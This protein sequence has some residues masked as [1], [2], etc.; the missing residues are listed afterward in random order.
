MKTAAETRFRLNAV[1]L[2]FTA[3][4][5]R[6]KRCVESL[7]RGFV[8]SGGCKPLVLEPPDEREISEAQDMFWQ[9]YQRGV[10][11]GREEERRAV[12]AKPSKAKK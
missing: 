11:D 3:M 6:S 5:Y 8:N 7:M 12:A 9:V 4:E 1:A 2:M 10:E